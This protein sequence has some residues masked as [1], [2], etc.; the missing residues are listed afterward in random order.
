MTLDEIKRT[1]KITGNTYA[2]ERFAGVPLSL[3]N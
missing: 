2:S 1:R 3:A